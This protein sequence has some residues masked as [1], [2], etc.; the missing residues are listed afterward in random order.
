MLEGPWLPS[1]ASRISRVVASAISRCREAECSCFACFLSGAAKQ[2][3]TDS[4]EGQV[5]EL[6][7]ADS[8]STC[9]SQS[10]VLSRSPSPHPC[11][12][13][14]GVYFLRASNGRKIKR[15]SLEDQ[16]PG[17]MS[18]RAAY[19]MRLVKTSRLRSD[20]FFLAGDAAVVDSD[21]CRI[22]SACCAICIPGQPAISFKCG[23]LSVFCCNMRPP[24]FG[25]VVRI[26]TCD[27]CGFADLIGA[28]ARCTRLRMLDCDTG[29]GAE[30]M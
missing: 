11:S 21:A 16:G 22:Q 23:L 25:H 8:P 9:L 26:A 10:I 24:L 2:H 28:V 3:L 17:A 5:R 1:P 29:I 30:P 4:P 7:W 15:Q 18:S 19:S 6:V 27:Q 13:L 14:K 12:P 20:V